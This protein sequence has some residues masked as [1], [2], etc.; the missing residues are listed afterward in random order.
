VPLSAGQAPLRAPFCN[1]WAVGTASAVHLDLSADGG[2][3]TVDATG[4]H[5]PRDGAVLEQSEA[6]LLAFEQCQRRAWHGV[7]SIGRGWSTAPVIMTGTVHRPMELA[8]LEGMHDRVEE[9]L[10]RTLSEN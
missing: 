6:D 8:D 1:G 5:R 9:L 7:V 4:D 3:V 2:R 10:A